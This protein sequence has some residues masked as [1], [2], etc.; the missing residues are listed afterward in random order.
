M[1]DLKSNNVLEEHHPSL[2]E[3]VKE[4]KR[5]LNAELTNKGE[6]NFQKDWVKE[7]NQ[8]LSRQRWL[9]DNP[10]DK[11]ENKEA[12]KK[13][14]EQE[15]IDTTKEINSLKLEMKELKASITN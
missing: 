1:L 12:H 8:E 15:E 10:N 2:R 6:H 14:L 5:I 4:K 7:K 11:P 13:R 3:D 9:I